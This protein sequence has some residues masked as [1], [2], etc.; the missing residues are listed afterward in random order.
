MRSA[1]GLC[2]VKMF[3]T[4]FPKQLDNASYRGHWLAIWLL[5]PIVILRFTMGFNSIVFTHAI[6]TSA[7]GFPIDSYSNA[8]AQSVLLLF[9]ML[10]LNLVLMSLL[11][12]VVLIRYRA[13]IPIIYLLLLAD[14]FGRKAL[15]L[16]HPIARAAVGTQIASAIVLAII[17]ATVIGFILSLLNLGNKP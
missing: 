6:A 1:A 5:I 16:V 14:E 12:V 11:G 10:G 15:V 3:G 9:A 13:M 2:E 7:D 17:A 8:G 4:L